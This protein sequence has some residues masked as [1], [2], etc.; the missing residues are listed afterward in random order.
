[1]NVESTSQFAEYPFKR[2]HSVLQRDVRMNSRLL[3]LR[4]KKRIVNLGTLDTFDTTQH[5]MHGRSEF[6]PFEERWSRN[7]NS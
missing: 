1:M 3:G 6:Q 5:L 4:S 7:W 2:Q